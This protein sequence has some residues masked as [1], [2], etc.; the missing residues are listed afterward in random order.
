[1]NVFISWSGARSKAVA[2]ALRD[3]LP[4]VLQS[5]EPWLSATDI[6]KGTKW[7]TEITGSLGKTEIGIVCLTPENLCSP[8]ILFEAGALSKSLE[9]AKVCTYLFDLEPS[10]VQW[11][12][13][14]FQSTK[15]EKD[16]TKKL[17]AT[18]NKAMG[19]KALAESSLNE[20]FDLWWPKL[21]MGFDM[22]PPSKQ[23][24]KPQ[25]PD[26][27]ILEEILQL[28]RLQ[29]RSSERADWNEIGEFA[30]VTQLLKDEDERL[31]RQRFLYDSLKRSIT[32]KTPSNPS[33]E[34]PTD[35][36]R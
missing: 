30:R 21:E 1:M 9:Q 31:I 8:W 35:E 33:S 23:T 24:K 7:S 10:N 26:R 32:P 27:A 15:A 14:M 6:E 2:E 25:R 29:T 34:E 36:G 16:E 13:A 28:V 11:P 3:W 19:D 5:V 22:I 12:L 18:L 17:I 20:T 4:K